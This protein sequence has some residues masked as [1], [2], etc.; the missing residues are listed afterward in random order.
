MV[1]TS[2]TANRGGVGR[3]KVGRTGNGPSLK[4]SGVEDILAGVDAVD[5]GAIGL[6]GGG[7]WGGSRG[8]RDSSDGVGEHW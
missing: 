2:T 8:V 3:L 5:K 4:S 6:Q 1:S 7:R